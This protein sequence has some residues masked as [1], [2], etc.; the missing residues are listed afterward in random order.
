MLMSRVSQHDAIVSDETAFA[1]VPCEC[2]VLDRFCC[3]FNLALSQWNYQVFV[4]FLL[5]TMIVSPLL[6]TV[7]FF[8]PLLVFSKAKKILHTD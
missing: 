7:L 3:F 6:K 2:N 5:L 4:S 8:K 1:Y